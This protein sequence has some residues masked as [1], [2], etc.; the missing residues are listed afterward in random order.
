MEVFLFTSIT[1]YIFNTYNKRRKFSIK[2]L[3]CSPSSMEFT[4]VDCH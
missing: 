4:W 3:T 1:F 2:L